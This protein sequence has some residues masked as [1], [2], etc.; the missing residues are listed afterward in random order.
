MEF[1]IKQNFKI[2]L[3]P[4]KY[5]NFNKIYK[6]QVHGLFLGLKINFNYIAV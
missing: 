6:M 5:Q 3:L 1:I 2:E 4:K